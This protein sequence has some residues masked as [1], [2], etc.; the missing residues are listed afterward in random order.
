MMKKLFL[1]IS[2]LL[3]VLGLSTNVAWAQIQE[4]IGAAESFEDP[5]SWFYVNLTAK[6]SN[7]NCG[8]NDPGQVWLISTE[9]AE[10]IKHDGEGNDLIMRNHLGGDSL[11]ESTT[12]KDGN[13]NW[14]MEP[15]YVMEHKAHNP[16]ITNTAKPEQPTCPYTDAEY[17]DDLRQKWNDGYDQGKAA[18]DAET[19]KSYTYGNG[20]T[21]EQKGLYR[22]GYDNGCAGRSKDNPYYNGYATNDQACNYWTEDGY[23]HGLEDAKAGKSR[24]E[25]LT[26]GT[27]TT[28][29]NP[30]VPYTWESGDYWGAMRE[31]QTKNGYYAGFD[32]WH[33]WYTN[34]HYLN[35]TNPVGFANSASLKGVALLYAP[36]M[37]DLEV[38]DRIFSSYAYFY[39]KVQENDG[40]YFTGWSYT[41]GE[42]DLG[43]VVGE[44]DSL[45]FKVLPSATAGEGNIRNEFVYATFQPVR[46]SDYKVNGLINGTGNSTTVVFDAVGER[47]SDAD[48]TVSVE[49]ANFSAVITSCVDKKVTVTVTYSGSANGEFRGNVTLASKSGCSQLTAAV[50]ARVGTDAANEATIYDGGVS[51]GTSGTLEDMIAEADGKALVVM[52]NKNYESDLTID[53]NV[54]LN[55]NGYTIQDLAIAGGEVTIAYDKYGSNGDAVTVNAGKLILNGGEFASLTISDGA[56]VEQNGALITGA[57]INNGTLITTEGHVEGGLSSAGTLTIN[58]GTFEGT[59][60]IAVTGGTATINKATISGTEYGIRTTGGATEVTSKLVTVYGGTNAVYGNGGTIQLGN[61]KYD[62][63]TPLAGTIDLQAGYFKADGEHLGIAVPEGKKVLNVLAGIEFAAG[64]R[65]F[66]G[67]DASTVGVCR[68]GTTSYETLEKALAYANNNTDKS[69]VIIMTNDYNISILRSLS[70]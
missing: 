49:E 3:L 39:G 47:V 32:W 55:F 65:Y 48:F 20:W 33:D 53:A 56:T 19:E 54:T 51:T 9:A 46:L 50:Y 6:P 8:T 25:I 57:V 2:M 4:L 24:T 26:N 59:T 37:E 45:L 58:G 69:V 42:S 61:G 68:I 12:T 16:W 66:V 18:Y 67:D 1:K 34:G 13:G 5:T 60:A 28:N 52:L 17:V 10:T 14:I 15:V 22:D 43:G 40:W 29:L 35:A 27:W 38:L 21:D 36:G 64:Y 63:S 31:W 11:V 23:R 30:A 70:S 44:A 7:P 62:A 41:E